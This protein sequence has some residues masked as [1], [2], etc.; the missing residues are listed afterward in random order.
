VQFALLV[1][2]PAAQVPTSADVAAG[3]RMVAELATLPGPVYLPGHGW[4]LEKA[5]RSTSAQS[6]A[7]ADILR[8][9]I[10]PTSRQLAHELSRAIREQRFG[11]IVVDSNRALSY[12]P[13][14]LHRYYRV[15]RRLDAPWPLTGTRTKPLTVWVRRPSPA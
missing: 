12:L 10:E 9:R 1:Y 7:I 11:A 5:G 3:N 14:D 2:N 8:A 13:R 4:Y 15:A 6:A